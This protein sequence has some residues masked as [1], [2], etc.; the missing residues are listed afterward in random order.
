MNV[1]LESTEIKLQ[2]P[3][4]LIV[5]LVI[6]LDMEEVQYAKHVLQV[7]TLVLQVLLIVIHAQMESFKTPWVD[8]HALIVLLQIPCVHRH[9]IS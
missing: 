7:S 1:L 3:R 9:D 5:P 2:Q 6:T 4:V 8:R